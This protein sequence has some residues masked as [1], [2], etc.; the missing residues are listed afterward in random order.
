VVRFAHKQRV[1]DGVPED[2][3]LAQQIQRIHTQ[4]W[5][6]GMRLVFLNYT[7]KGIK[8][9][10]SIRMVVIVDQR[11]ALLHYTA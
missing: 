1:I 7:G 3:Q 6:C 2:R 10:F 5:P 9:H 4:A 8:A 11:S